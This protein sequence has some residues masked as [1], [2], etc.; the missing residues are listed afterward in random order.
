MLHHIFQF[1][2][3][4]VMWCAQLERIALWIVN[5]FVFLKTSLIRP[6]FRSQTVGFTV[7]SY[8]KKKEKRKTHGCSGEWVITF[9]TVKVGIDRGTIDQIIARSLLSWPLS[10]SE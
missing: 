8:A 5:H 10:Y 3:C 7:S 6:N 2:F 1:N 9:M 4:Q